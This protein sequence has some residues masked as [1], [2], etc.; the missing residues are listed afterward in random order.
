MP[1]TPEHCYYRE[2]PAAAWVGELLL[3]KA[4]GVGSK[5]E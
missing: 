2:L 5:T 4:G 1:R 3:V